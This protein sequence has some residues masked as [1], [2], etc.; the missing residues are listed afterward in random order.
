MTKDFQTTFYLPSF[1]INMQK[2]TMSDPV[3]LGI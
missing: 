1:F 2:N 3:A